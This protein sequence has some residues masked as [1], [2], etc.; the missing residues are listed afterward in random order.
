M[1][2]IVRDYANRSAKIPATHVHCQYEDDAI[3]CVT[4][5]NNKN[6]VEFYFDGRVLYAKFHSNRAAFQI[7]INQHVYPRILA[8][9]PYLAGQINE[10]RYYCDFCQ[11]L[12]L[13]GFKVDLDEQY[14]YSITACDSWTPPY[15]CPGQ[16][17]VICYHC[18]WFVERWDRIL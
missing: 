16:A 11:L 14:K 9:G 17:L 6:S 2:F 18:P 7:A 12:M 8:A 15:Q 10:M 4:F 1:L 13:R 3:S 5:V